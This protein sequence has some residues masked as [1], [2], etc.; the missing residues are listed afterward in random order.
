MCWTPTFDFAAIRLFQ[1]E[2]ANVGSQLCKQPT[3]EKK[4]RVD[5]REDDG[6]QSATLAL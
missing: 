6:L 2:V 5:G 4:L 1:L 3:C